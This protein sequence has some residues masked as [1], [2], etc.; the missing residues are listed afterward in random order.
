LENMNFGEIINIKI[1]D[2]NHSDKEYIGDDPAKFMNMAFSY[3]E[4][5]DWDSAI[6]YLKK[7]FDAFENLPLN[8]HM[9]LIFKIF[10]DFPY[11]CT[12]EDISEKHGKH[13]I[14]F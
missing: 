11:I 8:T 5:K 2:G 14:I 10:L 6:D 12:K 4:E 13:S 9:T 3:K 1:Q 7:S